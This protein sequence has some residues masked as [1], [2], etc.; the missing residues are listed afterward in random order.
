V[1]LGG[2]QAGYGVGM[3]LGGAALGIWGHRVKSRVKVAFGGLALSGLACLGAGLAPASALWLLGLSWMTMAAFNG[4]GNGTLLA[5]VQGS[6][7]PEMQGRINAAITSLVMLATP[8]GLAVAAPVVGWLGLRFWYVFAAVTTMSGC[9]WA[10]RSRHVRAL[11]R[12]ADPG[13]P[14]LP[15][16]PAQVVGGASDGTVA[17]P[18]PASVPL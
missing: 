17:E 7:A 4:I 3:I 10:A 5:L 1:E 16:L 15:L 2:V 12:L 9:L 6:L 8:L 14:S 18:R 13:T 11:E